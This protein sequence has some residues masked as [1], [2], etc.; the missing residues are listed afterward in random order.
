MNK[1]KILRAEIGELASALE[2]MNK[3]ATPQTAVTIK[4]ANKVF[5]ETLAKMQAELALLEADES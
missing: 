3:N 2:R 4:V 1:I 5:G